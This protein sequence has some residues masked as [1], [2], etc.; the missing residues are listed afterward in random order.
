M[1]MLRQASSLIL[2]MLRDG[3]SPRPQVAE[4]GVYQQMLDRNTP[5][6]LLRVHLP[7]DAPEFA[8]ISGSKHFFTVRFLIQPET[9]DR[10]VQ[11]NAPVTFHLSCCAL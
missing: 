9:R 5:Y 6:Q 4:G 11:T 8:E 1:E 7:A 10:P 2:R 3:C